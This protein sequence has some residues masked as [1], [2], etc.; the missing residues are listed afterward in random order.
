MTINQGRYFVCCRLVRL[1][2]VRKVFFLLIRNELMN[3]ITGGK[4]IKR[5]KRRMSLLGFKP[6]RLRGPMMLSGLWKGRRI[7]FHR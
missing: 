2:L 4:A 6:A 5:A 7:L 1:L 3:T